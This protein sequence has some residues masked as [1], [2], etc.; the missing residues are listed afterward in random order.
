M[1]VTCPALEPAYTEMAA[2]KVSMDLRTVA[3]ELVW[4]SK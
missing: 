1:E 4:A 2:H 3:H